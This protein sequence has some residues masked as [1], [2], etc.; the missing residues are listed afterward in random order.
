MLLWPCYPQTPFHRPA[1]AKPLLAINYKH[2]LGAFGM[3]LRYSAQTTAPAGPTFPHIPGTWRASVMRT[4]AYN[5]IVMP[6]RVRLDC[7]A[8]NTV[9]G[10]FGWDVEVAH[11]L[12]QVE[13]IGAPRRT[14]GVLFNRDAFGP[15]YSWQ[16]AIRLLRALLPGVCL[17]A[18]YGFSE[19]V[20]WQELSDAGAFH[21]L[22]LPL[23]ENEVRQSLGFLAR[24]PAG[25]VGRDTLRVQLMSNPPLVN[26]KLRPQA[27]SAAHL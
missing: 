13:A 6:G 16:E 1:D 15:G 18:L 25:Q 17:V 20:D 23:K 4:M 8:L 7:S 5:I 26:P 22:W 21:S 2:R 12:D 10:E 11:D 3:W 14:R 27:L 19:T 24:L 9:A